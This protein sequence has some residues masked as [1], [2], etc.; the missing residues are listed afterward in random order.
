M[1]GHAEVQQLMSDDEILE[2]GWLKGQILGES[3][4]SAR[5]TRA[6]FACHALYTHQARPSPQ[7][8]RPELDPFQ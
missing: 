8:M 3:D 2:T 4:D 1:V 7:P 6:P 5:G